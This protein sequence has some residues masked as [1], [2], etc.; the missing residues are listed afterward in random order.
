MENIDKYELVKI[1]PK[2]EFKR[3]KENQRF[4]S[5]AK[6]VLIYKDRKFYLF[7]SVR[8]DVILPEFRLSRLFLI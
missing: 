8:H 2:F 5:S 7:S 1:A 4:S 6:V 3:K